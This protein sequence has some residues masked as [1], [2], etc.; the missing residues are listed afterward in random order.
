MGNT[1]VQWRAAI[2]SFCGG[3]S[4]RRAAARCGSDDVDYSAADVRDPPGEPVPAFSTSRLPWKVSALGLLLIC[5]SLLCHGKLL[6]ISGVESNPGPVIIDDSAIADTERDI[7]AGLCAQAP[8][9]EVRDVL[10]LYPLDAQLG[11]HKKPF[12]RSGITKPKLVKTMDY[13][14]CPGMEDYKVDTVIDNL[15]IAIQALLPDKCSFCDKTYVVEFGEKV[16]L[17]CVFCGQGA[18][19]DCVAEKCGLTAEDV[20]D[21]TPE[22]VH[23]MIFPC[24]IPG[25]TYTC[26][27]CIHKIPSKD[28]GKL[29][30]AVA[31]AVPAAANGGA[32][33]PI[34]E[35]P[36]AEGVPDEPAAASANEDA[37]V[38]ADPVL[39]T[40]MPRKSGD[41]RPSQDTPQICQ[42]YKKGSCRFGRKGTDCPHD[43]PRPCRRLLNHGTNPTRGCLKGDACDGF[44]PDM[45]NASLTTGECLDKS[46]KKPHVRGARRHPKP[47][48]TNKTTTPKPA[49]DRATCQASRDKLECLNV[50]CKA[51][52]LPGTRRSNTK[53]DLNQAAPSA[54]DSDSVT[55]SPPS[56]PP[57]S[58]PQ[59]DFLGLLTAMKSEIMGALDV[60][61]Q[62]MQQPPP[63]QYQRPLPQQYQLQ[64]G[65]PPYRHA[66][67]MPQTVLGPQAAVQATV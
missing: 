48:K 21:L 49:R 28:A 41:R 23:Q 29:K 11:E 65:M 33:P 12:K 18:H 39:L 5:L 36:E 31:A 14:K 22:K 20:P 7:L 42:H 2:G 17:S 19:S 46:C 50:K 55:V 6:L 54:P 45:C 8:D 9:T 26:N 30:A 16:L 24:D 15:V 32:L 60:K 59:V 43:H 64:W 52:H 66:V 67:P 57:P 34:A 4:L 40:R 27:A 3:G 62:S 25:L 61:L 63:Q 1:L 38:V 58:A 51:L 44:H 37:Q 56:A 53:R 35:A 13:L 10:R 47:A